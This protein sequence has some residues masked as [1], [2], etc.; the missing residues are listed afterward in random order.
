MSSQVSLEY[1]QT[2]MNRSMVSAQNTRGSAVTVLLGGTPVPLPSVAY[3]N[4]FTITNNNTFRV[5]RA[6]VYSISYNVET[7]LSLA[8]SATVYRNGSSIPSLV[9]SSGLTTRSFTCST[10]VA[11]DAED[12]LQLVLYGLLGTAILT[13]GVGAFLNIIQLS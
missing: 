7:T 8:L 11:L 9:K 12:T 6:G 4:G 2:Y 10:I 3:N 1:L 5:S 13:G